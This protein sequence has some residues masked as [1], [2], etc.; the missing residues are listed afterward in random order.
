MKE[1]W[2]RRYSGAEYIYG[3]DANRFLTEQLQNLKPGKILFPAEGEGRNAVFAAVHN[4]QVSAFDYSNEAMKKALLLARSQNV[5]INYSVCSL[6]DFSAELNSFDVISFIY[7]HFD[8]ELR[9]KYFPG[10]LAF[11]KPGGKVILE[12]F[13]KAQLAR[14]TGG[15][16]IQSLLYS[17]DE[18][19]ELFPGFKMDMIEEVSIILDEG[20]LHSGEAYVIRMLATKI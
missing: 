20:K 15:P 12:V 7:T 16:K 3:I 6:E 18:I 9:E 13:S 10:L 4:W 17:L 19:I 2:D 11:L 5:T 14:T 1:E 8:S